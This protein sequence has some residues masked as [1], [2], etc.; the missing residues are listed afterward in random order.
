ML[1]SDRDSLVLFVLFWSSVVH[2][3]TQERPFGRVVG[4]DWDAS[5]N[6]FLKKLLIIRLEPIVVTK[7]Y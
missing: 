7:P 2:E 4:H 6:P 1:Y 5:T 3:V